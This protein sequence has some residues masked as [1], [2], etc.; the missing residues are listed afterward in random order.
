V[1]PVGNSSGNFLLLI[2]DGSGPERVP[3]LAHNVWGEMYITS[4]SDKRGDF[5]AMAP[6]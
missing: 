3:V 1:L 2:T 6:M 5:L 4:R